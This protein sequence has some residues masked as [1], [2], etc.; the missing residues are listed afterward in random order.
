MAGCAGE[1]MGEMDDR[2]FGSVSAL[3]KRMG[4]TKAGQ[5]CREMSARLST[6]SNVP[7]HCAVL[8]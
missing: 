3:G 8:G 6:I 4:D 7:G 1:V 2:R 5:R